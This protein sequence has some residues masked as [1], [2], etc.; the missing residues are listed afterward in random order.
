MLLVIQSYLVFDYHVMRTVELWQRFPGNVDALHTDTTKDQG[1]CYSSPGYMLMC[2]NTHIPDDIKDY[3][4]RTS[5][6][7]LALLYLWLMYFFSDTKILSPITQFNIQ[8][9]LKLKSY[10]VWL[11]FKHNVLK[12][13][14]VMFVLPSCLA[15]PMACFG[16]GSSVSSTNGRWG[17]VLE[18]CLKT[19]IIFPNLSGDTSS[20]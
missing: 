6:L 2:L 1:V 8:R 19:A 4:T 3:T 9:Q 20:E 13:K 7:I 18:T 10:F 11:K 5:T 16:A 12:A 14:Q 15:Q 17:S